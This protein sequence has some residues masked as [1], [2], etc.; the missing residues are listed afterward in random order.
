MNRIFA[1][2]ASVG[3]VL[4]LV[5]IAT[6]PCPA[7]TLWVDGNSKAPVED[8]SKDTPFKTIAV[9]M[10]IVRPGD[11]VLI[12]AGTYRE[13]FRIPG[14]EPNRPIT[15]RAGDG[16]RV[17]VSGCVPLKGWR[18]TGDGLWSTTL[19]FRPD[20][21]FL[22]GKPLPLSREPNE[23]WWRS[24]VAADHVLSDPAHLTDV[25]HSPT[26]GEVRV[27]LQHGNVFKTFSVD[28]FDAGSAQITLGGFD[29]YAKLTDGD[30][31][32]L[33][34]HT[35]YIDR[36]GEWAVV[37]DQERFKVF[38]KLQDEDDLQPSSGV[39]SR[40]P[41]F[42][43]RT[44]RETRPQLDLQ[45]IEAPRGTRSLVTVRGDYVQIEGLELVGS[46]R[47]GIEVTSA[48][49]VVVRRCAAYHNA[50][51]GI[52]YRDVRRGI[53]AQNVAWRNRSG[54]SVSYSDGV[55]VEQND[56]A[57][58]GVDGVL[59]TWQSENVTVRQNCI[60]HHLLWGHPDNVQ[61]YRDVKNVR[62]EDNL[63]LAAG[64]S[65]MMEDT[66]DGRFT[67]NMLIGCGA[68]MLIMGH[69]SAGHYQIHGNTLA[70]SGY[71][72]MNL[73]WENYDVRHNVMMTGHGGTLFGVRGI[74][75]YTADRNLFWGSSRVKNPQIIA[76]DA[77]WLRDF[78][79]VKASTGQDGHS[80]YADPKFR[81]APV[82]FRVLDSR[83]LDECTKTTWYLR[84]SAEGFL[85]GDH[86]EVNFDGVRRRIIVVD[87]AAITV[88]PGLEEKPIKGWLVANWAD[89]TDFRLDLRLAAD[90]PGATLSDS[91]T[92]VG[93][94]IDVQAYLTGDFNGDG[95]PDRPAI[96]PE[97]TQ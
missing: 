85:E 2:S 74:E 66:R 12:R 87:G 95:Q 62:F 84:G 39:V 26:G 1:S 60:H 80:I 25:K 88:E 22:H 86:V 10:E 38:V 27:W 50:R 51:T 93:S 20:R 34:N 44:G 45:G 46:G 57:H 18:K 33:Q 54:I 17:V 65:V 29:R 71:G 89:A 24:V 59:V 9:A 75:G 31:Y 42:G 16:E 13:R 7:V 79:A 77:G 40:P 72:C 43:A 28:G 5:L 15:V 68:N 67:G 14:G 37:P 30:K 73:T 55:I 90:S 92:P 56:V 82:A 91:G 32:H 63:L 4:T 70:F 11:T 49:D 8:G 64:Q 69:E 78:D 53:V 97:L 19:D 81:S 76:T 96:P 21:L 23:G 83:R 48:A 41:H 36:P 3:V 35:A 61:V 58:N 47:D 6:T 94:R 52:S